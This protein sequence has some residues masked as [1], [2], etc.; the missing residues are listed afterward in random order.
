MNNGKLSSA[1]LKALTSFDN[2]LASIQ[3]VVIE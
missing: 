3:I 1:E 2:T